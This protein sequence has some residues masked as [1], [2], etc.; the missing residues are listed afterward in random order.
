MDLSTGEFTYRVTDPIIGTDSFTF[1]A[2]DGLTAGSLITATVSINLVAATDSDNDGLY[3]DEENTIGT[4]PLV[5][6]ITG[7]IAHT[8]GGA[9]FD[10]NASTVWQTD[11]TELHPHSID[12][13][14]GYAFNVVGFIYTPPFDDGT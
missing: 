13:D 1:T 6:N 8:V 7:R 11:G 3:D 10:D 12:I 9:A 14:L 5:H 4:N 2:D